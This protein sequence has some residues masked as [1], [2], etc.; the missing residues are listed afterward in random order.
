MWT[1]NLTKMCIPAASMKSFQLANSQRFKRVTW[2]IIPSVVL[3]GSWFHD[4]NVE[5]LLLLGSFWIRKINGISVP[6]IMMTNLFI[7]PPDLWH[8]LLEAR[9]ITPQSSHRVLTSGTWKGGTKSRNGRSEYGILVHPIS[10]LRIDVFWT[11]RIL[12]G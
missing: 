4:Q 3:V 5:V 6:I 12:W 10:G 8:C 9:A 11:L 7:R 2:S 1:K